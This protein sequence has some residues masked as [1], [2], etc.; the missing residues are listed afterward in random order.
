[1]Y[2]EAISLSMWSLAIA[3]Y[4]VA[5]AERYTYFINCYSFIIITYFFLLTVPVRN[6]IILHLFRRLWP[7]T[8]AEIRRL[9]YTILSMQAVTKSR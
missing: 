7:I 4:I 2:N 1:M 5:T 6:V 3:A 9:H 8:F